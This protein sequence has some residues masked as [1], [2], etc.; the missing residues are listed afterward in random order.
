[1]ASSLA[2]RF[3]HLVNWIL[4]DHAFLEDHFVYSVVS[5]N[6]DRKSPEDRIVPLPNGLNGLKWGIT[7]CLLTKMILQVV[8]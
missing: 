7:Y 1:M 4:C 3:E 6:G 5:K 2:L 8:R